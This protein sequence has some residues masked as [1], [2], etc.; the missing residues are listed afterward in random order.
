M[1]IWQF[2]IIM[3]IFVILQPVAWFQRAGFIIYHLHHCHTLPFISHLKEMTSCVFIVSFVL[4][5]PV[6]VLDRWTSRTPPGMKWCRCPGGPGSGASCKPGDPGTHWRRRRP[7]WAHETPDK[8]GERRMELLERMT[9]LSIDC[10][11]GCFGIGSRGSLSAILMTWHHLNVT[12]RRG[13]KSGREEGV[14]KE[15]VG[16]RKMRSKKHKRGG[17]G[18]KRKKT[19]DSNSFYCICRLSLKFSLAQRADFN[20]A[21]HLSITLLCP[22]FGLVSTSKIL[23]LQVQGERRNL[24]PLGASFF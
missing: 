7:H 8:G 3:D 5:V 9:P 20:P 13:T 19:D 17:G 1:V 10:L 11:K 24:V 4:F 14:D 15:V 22:A 23:S 2:C 18:G 21:L 6:L 16:G 12:E